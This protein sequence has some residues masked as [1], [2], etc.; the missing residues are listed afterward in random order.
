VPDKS[1]RE[2]VRGGLGAVLSWALLETLVTRELFAGE[3]KPIATARTRSTTSI[4]TTPSACR[5]ACCAHGSSMSTWR[6]S[7]T[8]TEATTSQRRNEKGGRHRDPPNAPVLGLGTV[9]RV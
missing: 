9:R 5:A 2:S 8:A 3:I 1:R 4:P 7:A 6:S